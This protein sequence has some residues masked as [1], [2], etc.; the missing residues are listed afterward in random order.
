MLQ[1]QIKKVPS[2]KLILY[3]SNKNVSK[4]H[5]LILLNVKTLLNKI[6]DNYIRKINALS[7]KICSD[8]QQINYGIKLFFI[9][10]YMF[11]TFGRC[12]KYKCYCLRPRAP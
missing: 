6:R 12:T 7:V 3:N 1:N 5:R 9:I 10:N 2:P 8:F 4:L 11:S